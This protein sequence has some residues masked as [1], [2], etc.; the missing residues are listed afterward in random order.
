MPHPCLD[1]YGNGDT[2]TRDEKLET[3]DN[4]ERVI[5]KMA[6]S[7]RFSKKEYTVR[8]VS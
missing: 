5:R 3:G 7:F 8:S 6:M 4:V 2:N 1:G